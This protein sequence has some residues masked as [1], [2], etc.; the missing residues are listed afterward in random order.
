MKSCCILPRQLKLI[1]AYQ[2]PS[3][4]FAQKLH[5]YFLALN[6]NVDIAIIGAGPSG[7]CFAQMLAHSGLS[8][9]ILDRQSEDALANP[10]FDGREIAITHQSA[11]WMRELGM[12]QRIDPCAISPI[13]NARIMNGL[14]QKGMLIDH[15]DTQQNELGFLIANHLIR[16][17]AY[18]AVKSS[19]SIRLLSNA[20][21][22]QLHTNDHRV[23]ITLSDGQLIQSQL[24]IGADSRFSE[25]RRQMGISADMHDF[26]KSMLVCVMSHEINHQYSAWEWFDYGQTL[27]LLPM[28][29]KSSSIVVTLPAQE[30]NRLMQL[31]ESDFNLE[32]QQLFKNRL[33]KMQLSSTRH[34]YPLVTVYAKRFIAKRFALIGDAAVGMHP[35]TAHGFNFALMGADSLAREIKSALIAK[36]SIAGDTLLM[37]YEKTHQHNTKPLFLSTHAIA[38]L[39]SDDRL[40]ARLIRNASIKLANRIQPL[41]SAIANRLTALR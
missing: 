10:A 20:Q 24:L 40:P 18:Q 36:Q 11:K 37:R 25:T 19:P 15:R 22:S 5:I 35:V 28:N 30:I 12:W 26:G 1:D 41:K 29:D 7:F 13:R 17:S 38:K 14:S 39:Y 2:C 21:I 4:D 31:S 3:F 33:G 27:A 16:K 34:A 23:E 9:V 6:M 8:I 32:M